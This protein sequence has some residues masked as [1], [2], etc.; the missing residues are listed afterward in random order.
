MI[1]F[2]WPWV[3]AALVLPLLVR[4]LAKDGAAQRQAALHVPFL[5]DFQRAAASGVGGGAGAALW[6][7][8]LA[9]L[10]LVLAAAR[11]QWLG[12]PID[13]PVAGRE[14]MLAVD[15]SGSMEKRDFKVSD[16]I[17]T[18]LIATKMVAGDFIERREG[19]RIGLILFGQQ[20]Y[21]QT[22]LTLDRETVKTLLFEA[23]IGFAGMETAIGD[24]IGLA[25]KRLRGDDVAGRVLVLLTDGANTAGEIDPRKAA[26]IAAREGLKIYTVGIGADE[27]VVNSLFGRRRVNP[28]ADLDEATLEAIADTT[29]GRYFRARD[30]QE[31]MQIYR[32]IDALEPLSK[33]A[34]GFRPVR[35]L[36]PWPLALSAL[37]TLLVLLSKS[38]V[39]A[40]WVAGAA[41]AGERG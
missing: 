18:R 24:A 17:T 10:A 25:I 11:P 28:S 34:P 13:L 35:A 15:I 1:R 22:P 20:A 7:L 5:Q 4:W 9:W 12:E 37:L 36:D 29:G 3:L 41:P 2:E 38:G 26:Q 30:T 21:V 32:D 31:L 6:V 33:E 40:R 16:R 23:Q 14:L 8:A 19:D 27:V 39:G